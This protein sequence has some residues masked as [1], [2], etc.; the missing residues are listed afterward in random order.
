MGSETSLV[1][2]AAAVLAAVI[3]Y[4]AYIVFR[5]RKSEIEERLGRYTAGPEEERQEG[6]ARDRPVSPLAERLDRALAGRGFTENK[7]AQLA[8]ANLKLTVSEFLAATVILIVLA[9]GGVYIF[10]ANPFFSLVVGMV[11]FF[12]PNWYLKFLH[13]KRLNGF[14]NQLSDTINLLVNSIRAGYSVLQA[15]ETVAEEMPPPASEE[16]R[17][18]V[19]EVQLG[20]GMEEALNNMLRRVRSDD[21]ELM[22]TAMNVQREV[23]GNLAEVLDAISFTIRERIRIQGEIKSLTAL[24]RYS[25]YIVSLLPVGVTILV[26]MLNREFMMIL[27]EDTCGRI[28]VGIAVLGIVSGHFIIQKIVD[29]EV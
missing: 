18:V 28:L 11:A 3:A 13:S 17:R 10:T 20:I 7:R 19:R 15:M 21:L 1:A 5:G 29:I 26:Y 14:N 27:F 23:G 4:G 6:E 12:A 22:V 2:V 8:R 16:F 9:A 25:G 24:G